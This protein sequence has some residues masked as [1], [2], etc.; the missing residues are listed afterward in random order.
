MEFLRKVQLIERIDKLIKL[1]ST[2][3]ADDLSR[4]LNISRRSVYNVIELMKKMGAPIVYSKSR[5]TFYYLYRCDLVF[6]F[7]KSED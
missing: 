4:R 3:T 7:I 6:G 5:R 1:N 2:G